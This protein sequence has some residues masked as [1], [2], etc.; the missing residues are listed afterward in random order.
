MTGP[1]GFKVADAYADFRIDV[2]D[3]IGKAAGRLKAK[4][5]EFAKMGEN[6]A[7]A[8]SAG[9]ARGLDLD[10][11]FR[12]EL[13]KVKRRSNEIT[14]MGNQAGE[15]YGRGFKSGLN[16]RAAMV[17]QVAVVKSARPAFAREGKQAGEAYSKGFGGTHL[18][19]P[20]VT[21]G[22]G[23][24]EAAGEEMAHATA[25][26]FRKGSKALDSETSKVAARTQAKFGALVF[27]GLS[28]GLPAAA[29]AGVV[30]AGA[31][32]TGGVALFAGL[33]IAMA[34]QA[35][36]PRAAWLKTANDV[37]TATQS[38]VTVFEGPLATA[39]EHT[40]A[41]FNRMLPT[42][43]RGFDDTA[44]YV[45]EFTDSIL[46]AAENALPGME[47]AARSAGPAIEGLGNFVER[48]GAGAGTM[49]S[50]I[51]RGSSDAGAGLRE[52]GAITED[53]L[54]FTGELVVNLAS[55]H[56]ELGVLNGALNVTEDALLHATESGSG[57]VG[58]LHGFGQTAS[59]ALGV[60]SGFSNVLSALPP[61]VTS[62]GGSLTATSM[63]LG[64]FGVDAGRGFE[65]LP[66][67]IKAAE[68][69]TNKLKTAGV[70]LISGA[71]NPA[72]IAT[73]GLSILLDEL[74]RRQQEAAQ[75]AQEHKEAVR[76][77]T[78]ALRQDG[79]VI[80]DTVRQTVAKSLAD[81]NAAGNASALGFK[82]ADVQ[83]AALGNGMALEGVKNNTDSWVE[84]MVR[85]GTITANEGNTLKTNT[86]YLREHGGA[87]ADVVNTYGNMNASQQNQLRAY[88]NLSGAIGS[89]VS[90]TQQA[91]QAYK[92]QEMGLNG[93]TAAQLRQRDAALETFNATQQLINAQL[94]LRGAVLNTQEATDNYNKV[95][96]DHTA[97]TRD[98]EKAT[99]DLERAQQAEIT[100][101]Y[102]Q[103]LAN[104]KGATDT[105]RNADAMAAA[106]VE[107][108][109]LANSFAGPLPASLQATIGKMDVTSA[110]A[111]GLT[112]QIDGTGAAVYRLPDGKTIKIEGDTRGAMDA[113]N[114]LI[115]DINGR[116]ATIHVTT[117]TG[118]A[119]IGIGTG[120]RGS[121]NAHG[122][123]LVPKGG[124]GATQPVQFFAS[125]GFSGTGL[126]P[127]SGSRATMVQPNT[128]R[129]VGDNMTKPE[130][131]APLD[132]S[133][134][135]K[136][137]I[138]QAAAHE[139]MLS[140]AS[141]A[142][143]II[144]RGGALQEDMAAFGGSKN[145][146]TY[147]D[148]LAQQYYAQGN[149]FDTSR[150]AQESM[151]NWLQ[152]YIAQSTA[153][154]I[155]LP[156][157]VSAAVERA[158]AA[159]PALRQSPATIYVTPPAGMDYNVI[160]EKVSRIM[161]LRGK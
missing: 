100:A 154:T 92:D 131:F 151:A 147:N 68:G 142:L 158:V 136:G 60:V 86:G 50:T 143:G 94:G 99:L 11:G 66:D 108:V 24:A 161:A 127:M 70:G 138:L 97:T 38:M 71:F 27:T 48:T 89:N 52:L 152:A 159:S 9:F 135:T 129:V 28:A 45:V 91:I 90:Q 75:K 62:F 59:G 33:G 43:Q 124:D 155:A 67:K 116:V 47:K 17:E 30:G 14:R 105:Q 21:G 137:F 7:K 104:S 113:V 18:T 54:E 77:L 103:G 61:Q 41:S 3:A 146:N 42:I 13:D 49:F 121:L 102:Q 16:L 96:K 73:L 156:R 56:R 114:G 87:A 150:S 23:G 10:K 160:A 20:S 65:G 63:L 120:G 145:L 39:A 101:A 25:V 128:W 40:E 37:T 139:G 88:E 95:M 84:S 141:E 26:G 140:A 5:G 132:G 78:D 107:A 144:R 22:G 8:F 81:K 74:G 31:V 36:K 130:L 148:A 64:K 46:T 109:R 58:F 79:G 112:V 1:G 83:A 134:R 157:M 133:N 126:R 57:F 85:S 110:Q 82:M 32:L 118:Y 125:G 51:A 6:A 149:Q 19:G 72:A 4:G 93:L 55:N 76:Q 29:L 12:G 35:D 123:L 2:D 98:K 117:S 34:A 80:G 69:A 106:N 122:N 15:G 44:P 119:N 153:S 111:A 53:L 115:R